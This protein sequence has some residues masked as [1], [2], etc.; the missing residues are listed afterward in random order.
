MRYTNISTAC[1]RRLLQ[2]GYLLGEGDKA[3]IDELTMMI[4]TENENTEY[5]DEEFID[6]ITSIGR[7]NLKRATQAERMAQAVCS[8]VLEDDIR[9]SFWRRAAWFIQTM[10][11]GSKLF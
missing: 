11:R 2:D 7:L 4:L 9:K 10:T 3:Y 5:S 6:Q 1:A 8:S